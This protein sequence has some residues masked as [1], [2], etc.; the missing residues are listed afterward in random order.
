MTVCTSSRAQKILIKSYVESTGGDA[1]AIGGTNLMLHDFGYRGVSSVES[2]AIGGAGHLVNFWGTDTM[3]AM[4]CIK[5]YYSGEDG[6]GVTVPLPINPDVK[7]PVA[8][9]SIPAAE[10]S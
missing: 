8:G 7:L 10:H 1:A 5:H 6:A 2:A 3:A 4:L 9:L